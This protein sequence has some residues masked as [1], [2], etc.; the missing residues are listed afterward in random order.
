MQVSLQVFA[1]FL[2]EVK[3]GFGTL[4]ELWWNFGGTLT[5]LSF[6]D[7]Q[8]VVAFFGTIVELWWNFGGTLVELWRGLE[9]GFRKNQ[10]IGLVFIQKSKSKGL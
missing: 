9:N 5:E 10:L 8:R 3:R 6:P 2:R 4:V 1:L 7:N